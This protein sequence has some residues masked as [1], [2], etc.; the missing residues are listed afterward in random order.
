[1][2]KA[3]IVSAVRTPVGKCRGILAGVPAYKLGAAVIKEAVARSGVDPAEINE[4]LFANLTNVEVCNMARMCLLEAGLPL[5]IPGITLNRNCA[6][7]LNALAYGAIL[8]ESGNADIVVAGGAESESR[9]N[10]VMEKPTQAYQMNPPRFLPVQ[11]APPSLGDPPMIISAENIAERFDISRE[12]CDAYSLQSHRKAAAAWN[13]GVFEGQI[14][15]IEVNLG[16]GKTMLVE[17]DECYRENADLEAMARLKPVMKKDGIVTAGNA[18]QMSDG[19]AALVVME[20]SIAEERGLKILAEFEGYS[21]VG[22]DPNIMGIGPV[23]A[24]RK[25]L[26][27]LQL[28]LDDVDLI[29]LN[30]AFASQTIA[31]VRELGIDE[32]K[33]NVNGG[34][35]A[36][37]HPLGGSGAVIATKMIYELARRGA[38]RGLVTFCCGGGQG[39]AVML[40][41]NED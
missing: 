1:M 20:K 16:K 24:T 3:V 33:L 10:Y 14:V 9:T 6:S 8:I 40:K 21:S 7:S 31:C 5:E 2:R 25:L 12:E 38:R 39:V 15:P 4:V 36:L 19:A 29:E 11:F 35:I 26:N 23:Y 41:R 34:A 30:E 13:S 27:K 32:S 28:T 37:G 18:S 17:K 22:V